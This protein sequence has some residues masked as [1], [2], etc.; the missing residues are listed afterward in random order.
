M[1]DQVRPDWLKKYQPE[2]DPIQD[3]K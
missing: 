1:L 3:L 2:L